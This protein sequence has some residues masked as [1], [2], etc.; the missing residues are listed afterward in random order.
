MHINHNHKREREKKRKEKKKDEEDEEMWPFG[1]PINSA[2][3]ANQRI[4][5]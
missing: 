2:S 3:M 1:G 5:L 4:L